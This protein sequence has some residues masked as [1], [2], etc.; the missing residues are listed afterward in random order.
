MGDHRRHEQIEFEERSEF[1]DSRSDG[2]DAAPIYLKDKK[3]TGTLEYVLVSDQVERA[4][5]A[6]SFQKCDFQTD[7]FR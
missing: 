7:A 3:Q 2:K 1:K 6:G 5:H 4:F